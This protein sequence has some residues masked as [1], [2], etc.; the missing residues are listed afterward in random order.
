[1]LFSPVFLCL[2]HDVNITCWKGNGK[3][4]A[5]VNAE[6]N[7][8]FTIHF[9][10]FLQKPSYPVREV[11]LS[12]PWWAASHDSWKIKG[13]KQSGYHSPSLADIDFYYRTEEGN[14]HSPELAEH[15]RQMYNRNCSHHG[16]KL[17]ANSLKGKQT[18]LS[19][20]PEVLQGGKQNHYLG[21]LSR[22]HG[23]R[24]LHFYTRSVKECVEKQVDNRKGISVVHL[25]GRQKAKP[26]RQED[27]CNDS[28]D[29]RVKNYDGYYDVTLKAVAG[30]VNEEA[31]RWLD[32]VVPK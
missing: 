21:A 7:P 16:S 17:G 22:Y 15:A 14:V 8:R 27:W 5:R 23:M 19:C 32:E 3:V 26:H 2:H 9:A 6:S 11:T 31:R 30:L 12:W 24:L 28:R 13:H 18:R 25:K 29:P 4:L 20:L 10:N 1:M